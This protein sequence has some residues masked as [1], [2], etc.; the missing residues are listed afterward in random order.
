MFIREKGN[1]F[2]DIN[3]GPI[4]DSTGNRE[5]Y[6]AYISAR[7]SETELKTSEIEIPMIHGANHLLECFH[8]WFSIKVKFSYCIDQL[9]ILF[10]IK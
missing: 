8:F 6:F 4:T 5:H 7:D 9:I 3:D 2:N 10:K 1:N